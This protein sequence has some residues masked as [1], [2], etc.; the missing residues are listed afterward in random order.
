M[1]NW[2][3]N[4]G[5]WILAGLMTAILV[6]VLTFAAGMPFWIAAVA[7]ARLSS[8]VLS[9][10]PKVMPKIGTRGSIAFQ[11]PMKAALWS[12]AR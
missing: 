7:A 11:S 4:D 10:S 8:W 5:N 1:R 9:A 12:S 3:G 6:P 2:L